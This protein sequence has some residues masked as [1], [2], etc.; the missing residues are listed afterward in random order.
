MTKFF[1]RGNL[2][3]DWD[4]IKGNFV[5]IS[6]RGYAFQYS[7]RPTRGCGFWNG[8]G[9]FVGVVGA[10]CPDWRDLLFERPQAP[11]LPGGFWEA[12]RMILGDYAYAVVDSYALHPTVVVYSNRP[13][14]DSR[15][16]VFAPDGGFSARTNVALPRGDYRGL[17]TKCPFLRIGQTEAD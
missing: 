15:E 7:T 5:T 4:F 8:T 2:A 17:V 11:R 13:V 3:L 1:E 6:D 9:D 10:P 12:V 16:K 14:F